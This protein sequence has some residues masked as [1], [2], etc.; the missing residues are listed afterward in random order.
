MSTKQLQYQYNTNIFDYICGQLS[1]IDIVKIE[2][3]K[4]ICLLFKRQLQL[5]LVLWLWFWFCNQQDSFTNMIPEHF[6]N[7]LTVNSVSA[8]FTSIYMQ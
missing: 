6:S 7:S 1:L 5:V 3:L 2:A 8:S 4:N